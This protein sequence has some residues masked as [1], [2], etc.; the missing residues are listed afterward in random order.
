MTKEP[1]ILLPGTLCDKALFEPQINALSDICIP[2]PL[3]V[4]LYDNLYDVASYILGKVKGDFAIAGLSYGGIIAFEL[5]RQ[6]PERITKLALINTTPHPPSDKTKITQQRFVGM[7]HL[8]EFKEITTDYLKD[9]MLHPKNQENHLLRQTIL[10]MAENIG[11]DG[12]VNEIKAQLTRPDSSPDLVTITC[13]TLIITGK[14]DTVIPEEIHYMMAD[15][16]PNADLL[17]IEECGH[18]STLEQPDIVNE[19]LRQLLTQP[20]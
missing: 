18:L 6:A 3:P 7:A 1:L 12:F 10:Q 5:W 19:A 4:H 9:V 8:G 15:Q 16:I 11:I 14:Q 13:P 2:T 17:I 20:S